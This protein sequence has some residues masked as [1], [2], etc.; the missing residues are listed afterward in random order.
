MQSI[1]V[2]KVQ[3]VHVALATLVAGIKYC[4]Y[5]FLRT[6]DTLK[7]KHCKWSHIEGYNVVTIVL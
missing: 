3:Q 4:H 7:S 6:T 1:K 2:L 5:M